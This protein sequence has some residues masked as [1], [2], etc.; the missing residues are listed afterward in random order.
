MNEISIK[1]MIEL[2]KMAEDD[3][4]IYPIVLIEWNYIKMAKK[5]SYNDMVNI[6]NHF[7]KDLFLDQIKYFKECLLKYNCNE[8]DFSKRFFN[9]QK[10]IKYKNKQSNDLLYKQK[11]MIKKMK[12][13]NN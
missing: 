8:E 2:E 13:I 9:V 1:R 10:I 11:A 6:I 7:R 12:Y 5:I 4:I 3:N